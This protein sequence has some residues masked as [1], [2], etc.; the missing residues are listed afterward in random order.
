M[1]DEPNSSARHHPSYGLDSVKRRLELTSLRAP[2]EESMV[3]DC[4]PQDGW[5]VEKEPTFHPKLLVMN[6]I[7]V[8]VGSMK[9]RSW[10]FLRS[11]R[12]QAVRIGLVAF[13]TLLLIGLWTR[14]GN[15]LTLRHSTN[16]K[17]PVYKVVLDAG[18][19]GTR[20]HVFKFRQSD[21]EIIL[22][23]TADTEMTFY[24]KVDGGL[25]SYKNNPEGAR[26]YT[27]GC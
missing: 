7:S 8:T 13:V 21:G 25:S 18:S 5:A 17:E 23:P 11:C 16:A 19:T 1:Y 27:W 26:Y 9:V 14:F 22:E 3:E 20:I 24:R 15:G 4:T 10:K 2:V 6:P 12:E